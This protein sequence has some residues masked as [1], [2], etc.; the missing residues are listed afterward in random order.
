MGFA[1]VRAGTLQATRLDR[2][3]AELAYTWTTSQA[4]Y[5]SSAVGDALAVSKRLHAKYAKS[6]ATCGTASR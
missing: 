4:S 2:A 1:N 6:F 3:K 5:P